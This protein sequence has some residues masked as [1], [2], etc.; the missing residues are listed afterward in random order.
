MS[1][2]LVKRENVEMIVQNAPLSYQENQ[3]S[4]DKCLSFGQQILNDIQRVGG[5]T[6]ELDQRAAEF[7]ERSKKTVKKM[8]DK[9]APVTK[10]F[11]EI[12]TVFTNMENDIDP[13]KVTTVPGQ[14]QKY[15]NDY[16]KQKREEAERKRREEERR[17]RIE[18]ARNS[19]RIAVEE[20]YRQS[21]NRFLNQKFNQLIALNNSITLENIDQQMEAIK[22]YPTTLP[23][24]WSTT[25]PSGAL[26]PSD[27]DVNTTKDIRWQAMNELLPKFRE[28]FCFDL[29][30]NRDSILITLPSKKKE[31]Q[32]IAHA[33]AEEAARQKEEMQRREAE[34][35][36]LREAER[37]RKEE[38]EKQ[39]QQVR[40]QKVE[41]T[42]L[43]SQSATASPIYQPKT[44]VKK[45]IVIKSAL[46]FLDILN[47]W[48]ITE[49]CT[50]SVDELSKKFK[51]QITHCEK[52]ANEK[53]DPRLIES[54]HIAY[55]DEV[56]AK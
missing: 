20:D 31:L 27:L 5:M 47:L 54:E 29:Q 4:H 51:S 7:I 35:A 22:R 44:Q 42:G 3:A 36:R 17:Q 8:N 46:G 48:W 10:L 6:D 43:F 13:T 33:S 19:Y 55:E 26:L 49:G 25:V 18:T 40:Q 28:Q 30:E 38:E 16:A 14:L 37:R 34:E 50:L 39:Q 12:R 11:D 56:K 9:R 1:N 32:S 15:R 41:M 24:D 45:K 53:S 21:F 2:E 52:L 23:E